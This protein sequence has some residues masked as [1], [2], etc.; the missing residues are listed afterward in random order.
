[1]KFFTQRGGES[2]AHDRVRA[3]EAAV[4][5][6]E[7]DSKAIRLDWEMMFDKLNRMMGRLNARIRKNLDQE[8][9]VHDELAGPEGAAPPAVG[10]H[11]K[12]V[13]A[14]MKARR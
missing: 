13:L 3:L 11:Q 8:G 6:L 7:R 14:R 4:E 2:R 5:R 1:M 10:N 12:L 9:V